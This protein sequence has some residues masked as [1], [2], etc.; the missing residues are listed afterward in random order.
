M[1]DK[2]IGNIA[3]IGAGWWTRKLNDVP[4]MLNGSL[5]QFVY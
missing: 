4:Q 1:T 3:V 2:K 5:A